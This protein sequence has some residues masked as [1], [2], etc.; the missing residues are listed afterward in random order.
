MSAWTDDDLRRIGEAVE[1]LTEVRS[2]ALDR[3]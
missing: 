1:A 2:A 3:R